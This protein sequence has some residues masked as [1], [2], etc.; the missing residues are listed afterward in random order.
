MWKKCLVLIE[1]P[2]KKASN[3]EKYCECASGLKAYPPR[4]MFMIFLLIEDHLRG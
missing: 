2:Q 1:T 4:S 3:E